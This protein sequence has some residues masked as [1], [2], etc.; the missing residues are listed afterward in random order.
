M[1]TNDQIACKVESSILLNIG[2]GLVSSI[3]V[4][5]SISKTDEIIANWYFLGFLVVAAG[6]IFEWG[7]ILAYKAES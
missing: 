1:A 6:L 7:R 2:A 4:Y 5:V 3:V